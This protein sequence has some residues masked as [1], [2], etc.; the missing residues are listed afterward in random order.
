MFKKVRERYQ[1]LSTEEKNKKRLYACERYKNLSESKKQRPVEFRK[2][3]Y[4]MRKTKTASHIK[5]D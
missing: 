4:K 1:D 2:N 5:T 3:Y